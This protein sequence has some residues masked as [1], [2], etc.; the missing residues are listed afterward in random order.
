MALP[1]YSLEGKRVLITGAGRGI[2][3]GIALVM[4]EA[5]ADVAVTG[6]TPTG[7]GRVAEAV[8]ALGRRGVPLVCDATK[9]EEMDRLPAQVLDKL[10]GLDVLINCVGDAIL[11]PVAMR[12]DKQGAAMTQADWQR[13]VDINLTEAFLGCRAFGPHLL[14]Q[15][16]GSVINISSYAAVRASALRSAYDAAKAGLAQFTRCLALEWA[17][18]DVRVN[19]IAPGQFPDPEQLSVGDM[20]RRQEQAAKQVPLRRV[21][22]LR[23]VGLLAAYL[24][25]DASAYVTGQQFVIDGGQSIA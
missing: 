13:I 16:K 19:A 20:R 10:G 1:E 12:P 18:Y 21:G 25:S 22:Q 8:A 17:P 7:V 23:E 5:G 3:K 2:G 14:A 15:R 4:A 9:Q 11:G 24:A 6:L